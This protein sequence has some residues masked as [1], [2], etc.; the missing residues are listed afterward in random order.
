MKS[1]STRTN[2]AYT[3]P[4][5]L[6]IGQALGK[7]VYLDLN[8]WIE[9]AKALS[10]HRDGRKNL[11]ILAAFEKAVADGVVVFPLSF[12]T[13]LE[14]SKI[15]NRRQRRNLREVI[16]L[17]SRYFV[18]TSLW[19]IECHEVEA[20][21]DS[22]VGANPNPIG[23]NDYIDWGILR[24][25]GMDG[26]LKI[27]DR[28]GEDITSQFYQSLPPERAGVFDKHI[29]NAYFAMNRQFI[30]GDM[31]QPVEQDNRGITFQL[32]EGNALY[33][34][35][36]VGL[37][38]QTPRWRRGRIRDV[39][40]TR[41]IVHELN[42]ILYKGLRERRVPL[43]RLAPDIE[44]V[45]KVFDSMPSFDVTVTLKTE[46]HRDP[47]HSWT[48]NDVCDIQ[49]LATTLPYCDVVVTDKAVVSMITRSG[50]ADRLNTVALRSLDDLVGYL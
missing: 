44:G 20:V 26:R 36:L 28:S 4:R 35:D 42:E 1:G 45:R 6:R 47:N 32:V 41:H 27:H 24:A 11:D 7:A 25:A 33:E 34:E 18:V 22:T 3:W 37:L 39:V 12:T 48:P 16:E 46:Y 23:Y 14:I 13:Y 10:G 43:E 9:L 19:T 38:N 50:L 17:L 21:L 49:A 29:A 40:A 8:H 2:V 5:T 30:E 15:H 31:S